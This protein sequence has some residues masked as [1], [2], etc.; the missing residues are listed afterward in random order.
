MSVCLC[1]TAS[2]MLISRSARLI[3]LPVKYLVLGARFD[4][5]YARLQ[6]LKKIR[7]IAVQSKLPGTWSTGTCYGHMVYCA[8]TPS[9]W[10]QEY[11]VPWCHLLC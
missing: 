2:R 3:R 11:Q 7:G 9:T 10:D 1:E 4:S 8:S 5:Y 6:I